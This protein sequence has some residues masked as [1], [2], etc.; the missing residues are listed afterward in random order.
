MGGII[1][2]I[3]GFYQMRSEALGIVVE[4]TGRALVATERERKANEETEKLQNFAKNMTRDV[5]NMLTRF[6]SRKR[7]KEKRYQ[8]LND[9]EANAL[10][11]F[12]NFTR[13]LAVSVSS[14]LNR[15]RKNET[16]EEKLDEEIKQLEIYVKKRIKHFDEVLEDALIGKGHLFIRRLVRHAGNIIS[17]FVGLLQVRNLVLAITNGKKLDRPL[18]ESSQD[19]ENYQVETSNPCD[20]QLENLCNG[21]NINSV[22]GSR[23]SSKNLIHLRA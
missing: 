6:Y 4:N 21:L 12:S 2:K 18:K 13:V 7:C 8:R 11:D 1:D 5:N 17:G 20:S 15:L 22:N 9:E 16:F 23:E 19:I 10:A 14:L 3:I